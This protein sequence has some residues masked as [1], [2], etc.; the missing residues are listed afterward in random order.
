MWRSIFGYFAS[1]G[2][3]CLLADLPAGW[4]S[5]SLMVHHPDFFGGTWTFFPD[6]IDFR[7]YGLLNI[8]EDENAFFV[9]KEHTEQNLV[10][11]N[12]EWFQ[13]ERPFERAPDGQ[14]ERSFRDVSQLE[15]VLASHGRS[16]QQ[17]GIFDATFGPVGV[18]GY[19]RP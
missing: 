7:R 17:V 15:L 11:A 19:P 12:H 18:D 13:P 2:L 1:R 3:V 16:G 10:Y 9:T 8:Y 4:E 5:L 14:P 6:Q